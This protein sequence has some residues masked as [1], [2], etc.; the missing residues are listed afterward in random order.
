MSIWSGSTTQYA[1]V[2][3]NDIGSTTDVSFSVSVS[4]DYA[5]FSSS[6]TTANWT[7]K[8]IVRSI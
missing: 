3:T 5:V 7:L 1:D 2:A 4:G 8:T 6:A